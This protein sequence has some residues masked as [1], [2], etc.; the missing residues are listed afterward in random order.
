MQLSKLER[1]ATL[2][3]PPETYLTHLRW[4]LESVKIEWDCL[5]SRRIFSCLVLSSR[6]SAFIL[7]MIVFYKCFIHGSGKK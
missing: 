6:Y 4:R 5:Q 7:E 3:H 1:Q 2:T